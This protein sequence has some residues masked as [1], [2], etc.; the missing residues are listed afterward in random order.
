MAAISVTRSWRYSGVRASF[1]T[2]KKL[3]ELDRLKRIRMSGIVAL[4]KGSRSLLKMNDG[5]HFDEVW[6]LVVWHK[7]IK[8]LIYVK[9]VNP[10]MPRET[11][12]VVGKFEAPTESVSQATRL[13]WR[14]MTPIGPEKGREDSVRSLRP[15]FYFPPLSAA[16][17]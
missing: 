3:Q 1:K 9:F 8:Y 14:P 10:T 16:S 13:V 5:K 6:C 2:N 4:K 12:L 15:A 7:C 17:C 11:W